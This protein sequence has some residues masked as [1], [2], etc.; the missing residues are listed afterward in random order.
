MEGIVFVVEIELVD[1]LDCPFSESD[2]R[3]FLSHFGGEHGVKRDGALMRMNES[4]KDKRRIKF[5][6]DVCENHD[7]LAGLLTWISFNL[8][9]SLEFPGKGVVI[10]SEHGKEEEVS[11]DNGLF[12]VSL[13]ENSRGFPENVREVPDYIPGSLCVI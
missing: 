13:R 8:G 5:V 12:I 7:A 9:T 11:C 6:L 1:L 10:Y 3:F 4:C 2:I